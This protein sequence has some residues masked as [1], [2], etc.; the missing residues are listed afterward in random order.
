MMIRELTALITILPLNKSGREAI[1]E[2][3]FY[4][5]GGKEI[6]ITSVTVPI[7]RSGKIIGV[8]G[9][10]LELTEIQKIVSVIRP[11]KKVLYSI[12]RYTQMSTKKT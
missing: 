10:D 6:L 1:V 3:N 5:V 8:T 4:T 11:F 12:N 9:V 2:P 7:K